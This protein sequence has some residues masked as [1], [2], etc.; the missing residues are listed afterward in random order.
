MS[1]YFLSTG[2]IYYGSV[3]LRY[4]TYRCCTVLHTKIR[5]CTDGAYGRRLAWQA[6]PAGRRDSSVDVALSRVR[7]A[8]AGPRRA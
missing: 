6:G 2:R 8:A 3:C 4:G 1:G 5:G 7:P